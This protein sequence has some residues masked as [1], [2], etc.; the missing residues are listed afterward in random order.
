VQLAVDVPMA[1]D[2]K[3]R[4][5]RAPGSRRI[6]AQLWDASLEARRRLAAAALEARDVV[7]RAQREADA[8]RARAEAEGRE[9]GLASAS[10]LVV[11]GALAR[12]RLLADAEA[13]LVELAFEVARRVLERAVVRDREAV[14]ELAVSALEAVRQR[15]HVTLRVHPED[16]SALREAEPRLRDLLARERCIALVDD[17]SVGRGG[18]IVETEAGSIDARLATQLEALRRALEDSSVGRTRAHPETTA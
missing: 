2:E 3:P 17:L 4:D 6:P 18:V 10:E 9:E 16:A 1:T 13:Q 14:V 8:I 7:E 5:L 12:E 11:R 15:K